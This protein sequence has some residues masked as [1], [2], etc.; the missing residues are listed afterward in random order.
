MFGLMNHVLK[1]IYY[2]ECGLPK[3]LMILLAYF[4]NVSCN[5]GFGESYNTT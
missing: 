3:W 4:N 2:S 1:L 5:E